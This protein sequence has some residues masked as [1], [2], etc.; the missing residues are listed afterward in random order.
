[1]DKKFKKNIEILEENDIYVCYNGPVWEDKPNS[2]EL[3]TYTPAGEDMIIDLE[4]PTK[5]ELQDY[6]DGFDI[7][8]AVMLWWSNGADAA[9]DKGVPFENIVDH[10]EDYRSYLEELQRVCDLLD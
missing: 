8:D 1:M 10:F 4:E 3:E 2:V 6:I 9:H 7:N 5:K